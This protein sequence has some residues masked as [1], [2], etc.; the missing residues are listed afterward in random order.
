MAL[1]LNRDPRANKSQ[2][3]KG[4]APLPGEPEYGMMTSSVSAFHL[5]GGMRIGGAIGDGRRAV[6]SQA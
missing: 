1:P 2:Q 4:N 5:G 3:H 6:A